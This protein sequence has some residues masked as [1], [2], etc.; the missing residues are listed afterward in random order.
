[1]KWPKLPKISLPSW[2]SNLRFPRLFRRDNSS[3]SFYQV[4]KRFIRQIPTESRS[5]INSY[6]HFIV[7]GGAQSGK[8]DLI[9]GLTEQSQDLY[10]FDTS[11][12]EVPDIQFYLGPTQ[13]IQEISYASLEDKSIK[14]RKKII[15]LWKKLYAYRD[16]IILIA[17][18]CF[19]SEHQN[20]RE[21]NHL[22]QLLA[23]KISLLSEIT[24]KGCKIR[25]ALTHLDKVP[26]YLEFA[27][28]LKQQNLDF[29]INLSSNFDTNTLETSLKRFFEEHTN[30]LL[31]TNSH[32]DFSKIIRFSKEMPL[33]FPNI[34]EFLRALVSRVSFAGSLEL[35]MLS[36]TS[37]QRTS[38]SFNPFQW[39]RL[40]S[41]QLFFRYPLLKHQLAASFLFLASTLFLS[42]GYLSEQ[43][44]LNLA[45]KGVEQLDLLQLN[46]FQKEILP[47]YVSYVDIAPGY[48]TYMK[49]RFFGE[50][51]T[52]TKGQLANRILKHFIEREV[53]KAVLEH[54]GELKCLYFVG[55][56]HSC[57][58]NNLGKFI[59][60]NSPQIAHSLDI[61]EGLLK[62]YV[63]SSAVPQF[64]QNATPLHNTNPFLPL[65]SFTP[66]ATYLSNIQELTN[67]PILIDQ[68]FEDV[69]KDTDKLLLAISRVKGDHFAHPIATLLEEQIGLKNSGENIRVIRWI[70]ENIDALHNYLGFILQTS[71]LP[72]DIEGLNI[73]QFFTKIK[74][75]SSL[76]EQENQVYHFKLE[77]RLF[78]FQTRPWIDLV[79]AHNVEHAIHNYI[80]A[81]TNTA[82]EIF[83]K[84]MSE[85]PEP[86]L[87]LL[88][89]PVPLYKNKVSV[90]GR[91][92]RIE[93]EKK[94][95][96]TAE[97]LVH[98]IDSLSINPEEK[99]R[100]KTF[101][102]HEVINYMKSYQ[103][104]YARLFDSY[105][106]PENI[107]LE[108]LKLL[109]H[110]LAHRS[111]KFHDFLLSIHY[112]TSPF[113][114]PIL[115]LKSTDTIDE[116][117]FLNNLF[118]QENG[119]API[120]EYNEI[121]VQ[122]IQDLETGSS[123]KDF[124][125]ILDPY[126]NPQ[127]AISAHILKNDSQSY[128]RRVTA[129]LDNLNIPEKYRS[130][131]VKPL[132]RLHQLGMQDL[133]K[134]IE[135]VWTSHFSPKI[136]SLF[137]KFPFD[138][139]GTIT[140]SVA[141]LDQILNPNAEFYKTITEVMSVCHHKKD[142]IWH[143]ID[144]QNMKLDERITAGL[145]AS[146]NIADLLWDIQGNPKA[147]TLNIKPVPFSHAE[148]G[149][150]SLVLSYLVV[151]NDSIRNLNQTP[152]W[153][154]VQI[155]WW[156]EDNCLVGVELLDRDAKSKSYKNVQKLHTTWCFF[157]L[158]RE[159]TQV[160]NNTWS[161]E[162]AN[163]EGKEPY[164]VS[165][166]FETNPLQLLQIPNY[167]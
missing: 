82:G 72:L 142:G 36:L 97:K 122:L 78:S 9:Q 1:M 94:V 84:N 3:P 56:M 57:R 166:S 22:A 111:S 136:E 75:R 37:N 80:T 128:L 83:F 81:N 107:S 67:H 103:D 69:I 34:E 32:Q 53:R 6:Q 88:T 112:H 41:M 137:T 161:W 47:E 143:A 2:I 74:E 39:K 151:G 99:K 12:T 50:K 95:K 155:D 147:I 46:S 85:A 146:Q 5:T 18:D 60:K 96:S 104:H 61:E 54:K 102:T 149:S 119:E 138:P 44:E 131:F 92:S 8:S 10:P 29:N 70:G 31:T 153:H 11:Y 145:V 7:L 28:F 144:P 71:T 15:Q 162:M 157:E 159:A 58:D 65:T 51:L 163:K 48:F 123:R 14:V 68:Q 59:L 24:K 73:A 148:G 139:Q 120:R 141:E 90:P 4:W 134:S 35:D 105:D 89:T 45:Q 98:L 121:I 63:L 127:A 79:I 17:Y 62:A 126:L 27:R 13:V 19:S 87:A 30:L 77:E 101:L 152:S 158:M 106:V 154:S 26:G 133:K 52:Q 91:Y 100:F 86:A 21:L 164:K 150:P 115:S 113:S 116:F 93:Y 118:S 117:A 167:R 160:D 16:P 108:N 165:F 130:P 109:L 132:L 49:P 64:D 114:D 110:D 25:I 23:G 76:K 125:R 55:L 66:W 156:K 135:Q 20:L 43:R 42:Y 40:P 129:S 38:T 33:L 140:I 124:N